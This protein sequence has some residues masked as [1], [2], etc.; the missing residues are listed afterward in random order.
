MSEFALRSRPHKAA[1]TPWL[2]ADDDATASL[3]QA[4]GVWSGTPHGDGQR[5][6]GTD[7]AVDCVNF[8]AA[9]LD[10]VYSIHAPDVV[11]DP[12]PMPAYARDEGAHPSQGD[13]LESPGSLVLWFRRRYPATVIFDD[14]HGII[15]RGRGRAA[16][17]RLLRRGDIVVFRSE[18]AVNHVGI[19][20]T[21]VNTLWHARSG[22]GGLVAPSSLLDDAAMLSALRAIYRP[23]ASWPPKEEQRGD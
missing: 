10:Q 8:V 4:L 13:A 15:V 18:R 3:S 12:D 7:G 5:C 21:T 23:L 19:V 11:S 9:V 20:G 14:P 6:P 1:P 2:F 22:P 17:A 16:V